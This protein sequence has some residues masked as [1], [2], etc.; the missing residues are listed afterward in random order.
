[1]RRYHKFYVNQVR[2]NNPELLN[3]IVVTGSLHVRQSGV[4]DSA[5]L[6]AGDVGKISL[7]RFN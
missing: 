3:S 4:S 7:E 6:Y 2:D 5:D 1:M